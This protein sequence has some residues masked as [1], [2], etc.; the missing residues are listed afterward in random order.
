MM[1][2]AFALSLVRLELPADLRA[3]AERYAKEFSGHRDSKA[4]PDFKRQVERCAR[5]ADL[6]KVEQG[7][8]IY[9]QPL[10]LAVPELFSAVTAEFR[11]RRKNPEK[12]GA[13]AGNDLVLFWGGF[14][15]SRDLTL[16]VLACL[17]HPSWQKIRM[18]WTNNLLWSIQSLDAKIVAESHLLDKLMASLSD[19]V[20]RQFRADMQLLFTGFR[21]PEFGLC[22]QRIEYLRVFARNT[23]KRLLVEERVKKTPDRSLLERVSG[24]IE[25]LDSDEARGRLIGLPAPELRFDWSSDPKLRSLTDLRGRVVLIDFWTTWC[26]PCIAEFPNLR[27]LTDEF[28]GKPFSVLGV[29]SLQGPLMPSN[30]NPSEEHDQMV[31]FMRAN[32]ITWKIAFSDRS[33]FDPR[34]GVDAIP[35]FALV[36]K[37]GIVRLLGVST[38]LSTL[39]PL[40]S[41]LLRDKRRFKQNCLG[42]RRRKEEGVPRFFF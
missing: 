32:T 23:L 11:S 38:N 20:S 35:R 25:F 33:V 5:S 16:D 37:N 1:V 24:S 3:L 40:I 7:D 18:G 13:W 27:Q 15:S 34:F 42:V 8:L 14:L 12:A 41:Q 28:R 30:P 10:T 26:R 9:L 36:D 22:P 6:C 4:F 2:A 21:Q 17:E 31:T 39:R 19:D 29:T